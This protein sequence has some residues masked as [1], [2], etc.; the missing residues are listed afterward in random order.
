MAGHCQCATT[1]LSCIFQNKDYTCLL[2]GR[3]KQRE[4][5]KINKAGHK[6]IVIKIKTVSTVKQ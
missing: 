3:K 4:H 1:K 2:G 6:A 5:F